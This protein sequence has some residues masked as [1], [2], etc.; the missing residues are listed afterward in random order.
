MT[1]NCLAV[2]KAMVT[3]G[4]KLP[5]LMSQK[6]CARSATVIPTPNAMWRNDDD[7]VSSEGGAKL[8]PST[9]KIAP[10]MNKIDARNSPNTARQNSLLLSSSF[11]F[12][13][14]EPIVDPL[15]FSADRD[16]DDPSW[17]FD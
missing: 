12:L 17:G 3:A 10:R 13:T 5:P 14:K 4:L 15:D 9:G 7:V 6:A 2:N 16:G 8:K 1:E 11:V